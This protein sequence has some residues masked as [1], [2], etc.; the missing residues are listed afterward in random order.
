MAASN[1]DNSD[2][3]AYAVNHIF[4]PPQL[5]H[6]DDF[7]PK[8]ETEIVRLVHRSLEKFRDHVPVS[9]RSLLETVMS[10]IGTIPLVHEASNDVLS[11][12]E[13][14]LRRA[15]VGLSAQ[16]IST[17]VPSLKLPCR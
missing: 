3:L 15:L 1:I 8:E 9:R 6:E 14:S 17:L 16:G 5:P 13:D 10:I 12:S 7:K 11:I 2:T 4:L